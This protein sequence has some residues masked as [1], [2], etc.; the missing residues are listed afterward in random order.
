MNIRI[1]KP[2]QGGTVKA[3]ASK[4]DAHRLLICAALADDGT[5]IACRTRSEDIDATA[6]CL[7]ALGATVRYERDGF[8]VSPMDRCKLSQE[9]LTLDCGESGSTLRFILPV[10]GALGAKASLL[11]SGRLPT[12]PLSPLYEEMVSHG[13]ILSEHGVSPLHCEGQLKSGT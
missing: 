12:R 1:T 8:N 4:S 13:C 9:R 3:I 10:C 7:E 6:G 2:I 5:F 11:M